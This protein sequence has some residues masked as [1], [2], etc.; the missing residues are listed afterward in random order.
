MRHRASLQALAAGLLLLI[1]SPASFGQSDRIQATDLFQ[2]RQL[3]DV[4]LSP[5]GRFAVYTVTSVIEEAEG[6]HTYRTQLWLADTEGGRAPRALTSGDASASQ[7]AWAP[8]EASLAFVRTVDGRPQ[9]F[10]LPLTGGEARQATDLPHGARSPQWAPDGTRLLVASTLPHHAVDSLVRGGPAWPTERPGRSGTPRTSADPDGSLA[11]VQAYLDR[12]ATQT[13]TPDGPRIA[14]V[15]SRLDFQGERGLD[16]APDYTHYFVVPVRADGRIGEAEA[17]TTGFRSHSGGVWMRD[18]QHILVATSLRE[19][20]HPDR[21]RTRALYMRRLTDTRYRTILE[22]DGWQLSRPLPSPDGFSVAFL[23]QRLA[24]AGFAQT[25]V[26]VLRLDGSAPTWLT[27]D[28]DRSVTDAAWSANGWFLYFTAPD[29]GGFPLFRAPTGYAPLPERQFTGDEYQAAADSAAVADSLRALGELPNSPSDDGASTGLEGE[30]ETPEISAEQRARADS[31]ARAAADSAFV[32]D[33]LALTAIQRLTSPTTGIRSFDAGPATIAY[34]ETTPQ[35][36]YELVATSLSG[37]R[38]RRLTRH[39]A[40][41][42]AGKQLA[43]Y[44]P[45]TAAQLIADT[46][47]VA[48][49]LGFNPVQVTLDTV[50]TS[51]DVWVLR[52]PGL[53][54]GQRAP[55]M[56]Q[57]HGGPMAMWGPGEATMW[58]EFQYLAAQGYGIVFTNPRGSGGYGSAFRRA[59]F[60]DWGA[61]PTDD[62]LAAADLA[63]ALPWVDPQRQ[64]VTGGSYAG[65]LTAWIVSQTDRFRAAVA[66]RG[67]YDLDTFFGEGNAWRLVPWH[68]GGYPWDEEASIALALNS[69]LTFVTD[70]RTPL[71][72]LHASQD[73]RTGVSQSEMLYRS[74]KVLERPVEYVRYPNAGHDLSRTGDPDQRLDRLLRIREFMGRYVE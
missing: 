45:Y 25:E 15:T 61:G 29:R 12:T 16:P 5:S 17:A 54:S 7:P 48:P 47:G 9:T 6:D 70:I 4:T 8:D 37:Q 1:V 68:F 39:N 46:V 14:E 53:R 28:F 51:L 57:I 58:H 26:G 56:V 72:I 22:L 41:W 27:D 43:R 18:G 65:Y 38:V 2:L 60:Q 23:G 36:P 55:L 20:V 35:N 21:D 33:S 44:E 74:L 69:P 19:D 52:P 30:F 11:A 64:V 73:L 67:V 49:G 50:A 40:D 62:V 59:N 42:L 66:Q 24:D 63:T 71:L 32:A 10:V 34:V 31:L 3:G 13:L